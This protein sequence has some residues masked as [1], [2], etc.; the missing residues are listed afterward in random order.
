M[1][2]IIISSRTDIE[3]YIANKNPAGVYGHEDLCDALAHAIQAAD[4]PAYGRDW[5]E[6]LDAHMDGLIES[7]MGAEDGE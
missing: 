5:A 6:W 4:H 3:T 7:V 2:Q 1:H